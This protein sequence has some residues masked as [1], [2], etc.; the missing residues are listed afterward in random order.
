MSFTVSFQRRMLREGNGR[1]NG[2]LQKF[3]DP[4]GDRKRL[5]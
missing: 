4:P 2:L 1:R 3:Q 5:A